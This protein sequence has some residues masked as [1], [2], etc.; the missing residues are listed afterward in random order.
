M[1]NYAFCIIFLAGAGICRGIFECVTIMDTMKNYWESLHTIKISSSYSKKFHYWGK[2]LFEYNKDRNGNGKVSW[3]E[4]TFPNDGGHRIKV[5]E[6][7]CYG[8]A[9]MFASMQA[10]SPSF[11]ILYA[12]VS[13]FVYWW[14][15][16]FGFSVSFAKFRK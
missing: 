14:V 8:Y 12:I 6:I 15:I 7:L 13:P 4:S 9:I 1:I 16:S 11:T 3:L 2:E 5:L 10:I